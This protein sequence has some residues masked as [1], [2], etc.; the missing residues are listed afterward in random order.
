MWQ[1]HLKEKSSIENIYKQSLIQQLL[2]Q[3]RE[4]VCSLWPFSRVE[5]FGSNATGLITLALHTN[6]NLKKKKSP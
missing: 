6:C 1:S 5:V 4:C 3:L 2:N